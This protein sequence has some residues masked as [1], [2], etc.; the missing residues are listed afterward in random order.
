MVALKSAFGFRAHAVILQLYLLPSTCTTCSFKLW[1][2]EATLSLSVQ[3]GLCWFSSPGRCWISEA[4][5]TPEKF[6]KI[7]C[8][9]Q[10]RIHRSSRLA[11][12][13]KIENNVAEE[14]IH[15]ENAFHLWQEE[16][17]R[18]R[19]FF[20]PSVDDLISFVYLQGTFWHCG[21]LLYVPKKGRRWLVPETGRNQCSWSLKSFPL[22][23][24]TLWLLHTNNSIFSS[25]LTTRRILS[26]LSTCR[27]ES[28]PT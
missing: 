19:D 18:R 2:V 23:T 16:G 7:K 28:S 10:V 14:T 3:V 21:C 8:L 22:P 11:L 24:W 25:T 6:S 15:P 9:W 13:T 5:S 1:A 20:F 12:T 26:F 17:G 4:F 27:K